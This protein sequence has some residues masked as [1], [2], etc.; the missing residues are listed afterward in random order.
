MVF[1]ENYFHLNQQMPTT[2]GFTAIFLYEQLSLVVQ[3]NHLFSRSEITYA[4][5]KSADFLPNLFEE[6]HLT[7]GEASTRWIA[8]AAVSD[9]VTITKVLIL[10]T[11]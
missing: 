4:K 10:F 6:K 1:F 7:R 8:V 2:S 3:I 9:N 5:Q 11:K